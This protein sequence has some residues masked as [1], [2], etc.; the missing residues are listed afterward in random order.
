MDLAVTRFA[1]TLAKE[2]LDLAD[3]LVAFGQARFVNH[4]L[5]ALDVGPRLLVGLR[6]RVKPSAQQQRL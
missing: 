1:A 3:Q 4:R 5:E 6:C 2:A